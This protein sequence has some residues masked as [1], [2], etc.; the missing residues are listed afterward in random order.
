MDGSDYSDIYL[1]HPGQ[2][3]GTVAPKPGHVL[4]NLFPFRLSTQHL[5]HYSPVPFVGTFIDPSIMDLD[6][7][8][9]SSLSSV[10]QPLDVLRLELQ[11]EPAFSESSMPKDD[12]TLTSVPLTP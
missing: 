9:A 11:N 12:H 10:Y 3:L 4:Y 7:L 5:P 2:L 6:T 8:D 1:R